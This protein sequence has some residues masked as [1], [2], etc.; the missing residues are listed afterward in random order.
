MDVLLILLGSVFIVVVY[1][2]TA[3]IYLELNSPQGLYRVRFHTWAQA[4]VFAAEHS[5]FMEVRIFWWKKV[6]DLLS[7]SPV[8]QPKKKGKPT[9]QKKY[10]VPT[11]KLWAMLRSFRVRQCQANLDTGDEALNGIL[12]PL[13]YWISTKAGV[14]L[15]INF[16][17]QNEI[18][19]QIENNLLRVLVAYVRS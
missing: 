11:R 12:F 8:R 7:P 16:Y 9:A 3:P 19:V 4:R 6:M 18:T 5:F 17:D 2:L 15:A 10:G 14:D 1:L 13:A